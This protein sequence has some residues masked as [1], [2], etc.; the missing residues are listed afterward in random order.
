MPLGLQHTLTQQTRVLVCANSIGGLLWRVEVNWSYCLVVR[1]GEAL[2]E[3][4]PEVFCARSPNDLKLPLAG[5][6][7][8]PVKS[9]GNGIGAALFDGVIEDAF[10]AVVVCSKHCGRMV[11]VQFDEYLLDGARILGIHAGGCHFGLCC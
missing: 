11:V 1:W 8:E 3:V 7:S 9:H 10:G 5:A 2:R 6:V 4:V